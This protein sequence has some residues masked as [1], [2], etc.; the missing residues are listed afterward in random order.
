MYTR[1]RDLYRRSLANAPRGQPFSLYVALYSQFF[2]TTI[3]ADCGTFGL[4]YKPAVTLY[5]R[6]K[7]N[8]LTL[9]VNKKIQRA[10]ANVALRPHQ[11]ITYVSADSLDR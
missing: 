5:L 11:T 8:S 2:D 7:I 10:V 6:Q 1:V 9:Q 3:K 4:W